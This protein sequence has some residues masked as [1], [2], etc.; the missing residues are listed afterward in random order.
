AV[1][2]ENNS[3]FRIT[4]LLIRLFESKFASFQHVSL[5]FEYLNHTFLRFLGIWKCA[6]IFWTDPHAPPVLRGQ[7]T[8][9][10]EGTLSDTERSS[11][12]TPQLI[13]FHVGGKEK[14]RNGNIDT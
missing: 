6:L 9:A 3:N 8:S 11:G 1:S 2:L 5:L 13:H 4:N 10:S 7:S 14:S 12:A